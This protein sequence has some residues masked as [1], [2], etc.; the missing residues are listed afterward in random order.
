LNT[1]DAATVFAV[2]EPG[3]LALLAAGVLPFLR[4]RRNDVA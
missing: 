3:S 4:R 2:P 1:I